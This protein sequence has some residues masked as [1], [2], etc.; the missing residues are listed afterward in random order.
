MHKIENTLRNGLVLAFMV[1]SLGG[2]V[3][4]TEKDQ[5]QTFPNYK[6]V[7]YDQAY[8]P[9][10]HFTSLKNWINDPNG[11]LY[12]DGEYHLF[13]QHNPLGNGWGNMTWGHAV[14]TDM[15]HLGPTK[16]AMLLFF[17]HN[18]LKQHQATIH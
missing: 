9:K 5:F 10:F 13:F 17:R 11:L 18:L 15:V 8:R 2:Q 1:S 14:S 12:Y 7:G 6:D 3:G 4:T 16:L